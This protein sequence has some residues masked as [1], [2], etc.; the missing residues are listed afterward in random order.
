M[1]NINNKNYYFACANTC[2]GFVNLFNTIYNSKKIEKIYIIKGYD[3]A[4]ILNKIAKKAEDK[5]YTIEYFLNPVEINCLN[6]II[7]NELKTAI[8]NE[9]L[10]I[11]I[12]IKMLNYPVLFEN[13]INLNDFYDEMLL[14][15]QK[16]EIYDLIK[17]KNEY[18]KIAYKFLIAANEL[19][20]I[21]IKLSNKYI[22][23]EKLN[24]SINR[25]LYKYINEKHLNDYKNECIDKYIFI[26]SVSATGL[27]ELDTFENE[28]IKIFYISNEYFSGWQYTESIFE[29]FENI[30]KIICPDVLNPAKIKAIYL[31]DQ[32]ILFIIKH[33]E[34]NKIYEDRY[35]FINMERFI[36]KNFKKENK[37]KLRFI[38]KCYNS[39]IDE[40]IKYFLEIKNLNNSIENIYKFANKTDERNKYIE[41]VIKKIFI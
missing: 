32:K 12:S 5:K 23:Q 33:K 21:N 26:N 29:K 8:I 1:T 9:D 10:Y 28:A 24:L 17:K 16:N 27:K 41:S 38:Y 13:I 25:I 20:E 19:S 39:I 14:T 6:G 36:D 30:N 22:N 18:N 2:I 4:Y 40:V 15:K 34:L 7:I 37:Q 3:K 11:S 35:N 31:K